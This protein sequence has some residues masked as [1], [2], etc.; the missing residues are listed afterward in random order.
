MTLSD[1]IF[2]CSAW[3]ICVR[4]FSV[5]NNTLSRPFCSV[6]STV[7]NFDISSVFR[8]TSSSNALIFLALASSAFI[9]SA[10][11]FFSYC[12]CVFSSSSRS[13]LL[14]DNSSDCIRLVCWTLSNWDF[15][16]AFSFVIFLSSCFCD[17]WASLILSCSAVKLA[18]W[19]I[20]CCWKSSSICSSSS[21]SFC[22]VS[23]SLC[24]VSNSALRPT[25]ALACSSF[26]LS[27]SAARLA[28]CVFFCCLTVSS[29]SFSSFIWFFCSSFNLRRASKSALRTWTVFACTSLAVSCSAVELASFA[30]CCLRY[31]SIS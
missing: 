28:S 2:S 1:L 13:N 10:R 26:T 24:A 14:L 8:F 22:L 9:C 19:A 21:F 27:C 5:S 4:C 25:T 29:S 23:L 30:F 15:K 6:S 11:M 12:F 20:C 16:A 18:S 17:F 7:N 3:C 31:S